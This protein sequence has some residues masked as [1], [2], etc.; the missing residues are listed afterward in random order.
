MPEIKLI[1]RDNMN[2]YRNKIKEANP[3]AKFWSHSRLGS[4]NTCPRQYYYTY[5]DK[6]PQKTGVY[7]TLGESAHQ[8]LQ[9]LY[10]G[11]VKILNKQQFDND[12]LKCEMFGINFPRSKYD[13]K[14][15]Y[16][17][18]IDAFFDVYKKV[19]TDGQYICEL[20]FILQIDKDNYELGYIDL[21][22]INK[23]GSADIVDFKTSSDFKG[24]HLTEAGRQ[25]VLYALA[26][27]QLYGIKVNSVKW[28]M[29]KYINVQI[30]TNKTKTAVRGREWVSKCSSQIRTLM[31]N[32]GYDESL[33]DLYITQAE[34]SNSIKQLPQDVQDKINVNVY[35]RDYK[36]TDE[37]KEETINYTK[38]SIKN[39]EENIV[40]GDC[41]YMWECKPDR[42]FCN[43][44]CGFYPKYCNGGE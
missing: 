7:S 15:G 44:L 10:E 31:K 22:I 40:K 27:E 11:K 30:G 33:I 25:L 8:T 17:K 29:L 42:F 21:L 38:E 28:H 2:E 3:K 35:F 5:I 34:A 6:K 12:F 18:D 41:E 39:I 20:G 13:I 4:Y 14:G 23:D 9:D 37:I 36:L 43:N 1:F 19:H 24:D 32:M 16:K 26:I